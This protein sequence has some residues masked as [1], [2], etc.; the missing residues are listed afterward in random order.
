[1]MR[2]RN[3]IQKSMILVIATTLLIAYAM[4]TFVIY[5]QT[6]NV[7]EDELQQEA[8]YIRAAI[9]ISGADYLQEM[10]A[11]RKSTRVTLIDEDGQILY[12]SQQG[13]MEL[14][15]HKN[16]PEVQEAMKS[17]TGK[18]VRESDTMRQEMFY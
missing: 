13:K 1:M 5:H 7:M 18:D 15:N 8:D 14:E 12:D 10:D 3:R 17:G 2:L 6:V 16:R 9:E 11:V 4:T